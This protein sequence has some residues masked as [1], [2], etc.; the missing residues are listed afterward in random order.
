MKTWF[1]TTTSKSGLQ[2]ELRRLENADHTIFAVNTVSGELII[3]SF[4]ESV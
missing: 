3:I 1:V 2:S 4:T